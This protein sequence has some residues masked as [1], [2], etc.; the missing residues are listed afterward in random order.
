LRSQILLFC[1]LLVLLVP[2]TGL[3]ETGLEV[4]VEGVEGRLYENIMA[5]LRINVFKTDSALSE[6]EIRRLHRLAQEDIKE[7]LAPFGYYSVTVESTL[8]KGEPGWRAIYLVIPGEPVF[9]SSISISIIGP[10]ADLPEFSNPEFLVDLTEGA[11]LDQQHYELQKRSL[12][13]QVSGLGFL[14]ASFATQEIRLNRTTRAAEIELVLDTGGRYL[15]GETTSDQEIINNELL[16]RFLPW[17]EGEPFNVRRLHDLQRDLNRTDYFSFVSVDPGTTEPGEHEV[18]VRVNLKPLEHYNLFSFGVGYTTDSRAH[19][20]FEWQNLLLNTNGHHIKSSFMVGEQ[21]S[22]CYIKYN[23]PV[24]DPRYNNLGI[25]GQWNRE[26]WEDTITNSLSAGVVYEYE[27]LIHHI[28]ISLEALDEDYRVGDTKGENQL[29]IPGIQGSWALADSIVNTKNGVRMSLRISGAN[30]NIL[31]DATFLSIRGDGRLI[32][33]PAQNWR[34]IA[35]GAIGGII[36]DSINDI[37]PSLRFYAGG[38]NSVRGYRY[39]T[40][41]PTDSSGTVVGGKYMMTGSIEFERRLSELWRAVG[42]YD[43]GNAMDDFKVELAHGVGAG[44][45]LVLPFGQIRLEVAYPLNDTGT[46]QYVFLNVGA[47]L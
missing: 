6:A 30:D 31:S 41:G 21:E 17:E 38:M 44:V 20:R 47:D 42:F 3:S 45:G 1:C 33:S 12:L 10:G 2:R 29:L 24:A 15:F 13:R 34:V 28:G 39:R 9:I 5:R 35:R 8:E 11:V 25:N 26:E 32:I 7:A 40:L 27:T 46:E 22:H 23:I 4:I 18:P 43:V 14:D 36:V 19:V 16:V 37:P